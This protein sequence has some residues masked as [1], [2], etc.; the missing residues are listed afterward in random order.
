MEHDC[1]KNEPGTC[2]SA[3]L[4]GRAGLSTAQLL[5]IF[6]PTVDG[7]QSCADCA[8]FSLQELA[9]GAGEFLPKC[10]NKLNTLLS[11]KLT[12]YSLLWRTLSFVLIPDES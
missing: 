1:P 4:R 2:P 6:F 7:A 3:G 9:L 11:V 12:K 5:C 10:P 8:P